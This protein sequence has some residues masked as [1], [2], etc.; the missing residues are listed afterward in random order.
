MTLD[1][2]NIEDAF[3]SHFGALNKLQSLALFHNNITDEGIN[4]LAALHNLDMLFIGMN[5]ITD[6]SMLF[7]K[8]L[9]RLTFLSMCSTQITDNALL[10]LSQGSVSNSLQGLDLAEN[11][12]LTPKSIE[13]IFEKF[14]YVTS[15]D[16]SDSNNMSDIV[17]NFNGKKRKNGVELC[18]S[19]PSKFWM[20]AE[21]YI[22]KRVLNPE[23]P[24]SMPNDLFSIEED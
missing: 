19:C 23:I 2:L 10:I 6:Q 20:T 7:I 17:E 12:Q 13:I 8:N 22:E 11:S 21:K 5:N 4:H 16:I 9:A 18:I 24:D 15:V 1:S 3:L 14:P